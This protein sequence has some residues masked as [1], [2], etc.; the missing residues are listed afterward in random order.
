MEGWLIEPWAQY[1]AGRA[2]FLQ[3]VLERFCP[4]FMNPLLALAVDDLITKKF[5]FWHDPQLIN[6]IYRTLA[7]LYAFDWITVGFISCQDSEFIHRLTAQS[8]HEYN[9]ARTFLQNFTAFCDFRNLEIGPV[10]ARFDVSTSIYCM[11]NN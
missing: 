1:G 11:N 8:T 5:D 10:S 3:K 2:R 9:R 7:S 6:T 4:E